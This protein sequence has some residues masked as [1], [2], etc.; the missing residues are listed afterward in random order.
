M[1]LLTIRNLDES[2]K[3]E[4]RI[5]AARHGCSMEEEARR[6]LRQALAKP[7]SETGLGSRLHQRFVALTNGGAEMDLPTRSAPRAAPFSE[8]DE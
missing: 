2:V 5:Q 3:S 8:E 6:I 4:L 1:A 7:T